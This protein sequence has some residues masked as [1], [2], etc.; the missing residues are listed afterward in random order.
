MNSEEQIKYDQ[1][2]KR[3]KEIKGFYTHFVVYLVVNVMIF[4]VNIQDLDPGETYFQFK[5]FTTAFFWG[6]GLLAHALSV[7]VP[8]MI[9]GKNWEERKIKELMDKD[10][11]SKW[12]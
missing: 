3:V 4:V 2:R 5:N 6:L 10:K 1:A 12:E 9:M 8:S 11:G 7:F